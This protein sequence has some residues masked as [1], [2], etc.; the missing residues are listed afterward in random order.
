MNCL[1]PDAFTP[2]PLS[3]GWGE[4]YRPPTPRCLEVEGGAPLLYPGE[5]HLIYGRGGSGKTW[6]ALLGCLQEARRGRRSIFIDYEGTQEDTRYRLQLMGCTEDQAALIGYVKALEA[7]DETLTTQLS[8]WVKQEDIRLVMVDSL[9]RALAAAG[10]EENTNRDVVSF[11]AMMEH[12][13]TSGAALCFIDHV[14]HPRDGTGMPSPR[15]GSAKVDQV[16][17]AYWVR[18]RRPW[19]DA[20][21]GAAEILP[22]KAR[23][24]AYLEGETAAVL[25]VK[26]GQSSLSVRL[27]APAPPAFPGVD[28]QEV[29]EAIDALLSDASACGSKSAMHKA[30]SRTVG[31]SPTEVGSTLEQMIAGG[32]VLATSRGNGSPTILSRPGMESDAA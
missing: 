16:T 9:A 11:F 29:A 19:S 15:G 32:F 20:T 2:V 21:E 26:P 8:A 18:V 10:L 17:A 12:L 13:R 27:V 30:V 7:L 6:I 1:P 4:E 5:V 24:G 31:C 14:G 28:D 25:L 22:R 3:E 23:H